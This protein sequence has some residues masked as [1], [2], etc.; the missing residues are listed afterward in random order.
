M[1]YFYRKALAIVGVLIL[2]CGPVFA[3][4]ASISQIE[5][6]V[7]IKTAGQEK[8]K[9]AQIDQEVSSGD[10]VRTSSES[11]AVIKFETGHEAKIS[12]QSSMEIRE[13]NKEQTDL[14]LF[15]GKLRSKVRE[16][17]K[18]ES[19]S[20]RSPQAVA[21]VRGTDFEVIVADNATRLEVFEGRVEA[22]ELITGE[23]V[24]VRAGQYT[25]IK[26]N[27]SP[28]SP[29]QLESDEPG[30]DKTKAPDPEEKE[31][32]N[33]REEVRR[34]M[35]KEITREAV[36]SRAAEEIKKA[37]YEN[38]KV[39]TDVHGNR[40][41]L[42]EYIVRPKENEFKYVVLNHRENRFDFGKINFVF[43]SSLPE[44]L[45]RATEN[46]FY[47]ETPEKPEWVLTDLTSVISNTKDRVNEVGTGGDMLQDSEDNWH[48]YFE[49]FSFSVKGA[50][51]QEKTLWTREIYGGYSDAN[52]EDLTV[53]YSYYLDSGE[54]DSISERPSGEDTFHFY[55]KDTYADGTWIS[56][57]DYF[58]NDEGDIQ[59][60]RDITDSFSSK[61][62][63]S[64]AEYL[65]GLN[66]ERKYESSEFGDRD[67]DL[68]FSTKLVL[69]SG[70]FSY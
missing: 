23:S 54:P 38:G 27:E 62:D 39:M 68:V 24:E 25:N 45:N 15:K 49:N 2:I 60:T 56:T 64:F 32:G 33:I 57:D 30:T 18:D 47:A 10:L 21:G 59:T 43:D 52:Y 8:W 11:V 31:Y 16:L 29:S 58:I 70:M 66:F 61:M 40:V 55:N 44:N 6:T 42:E 4:V 35:F 7:Q 48:H 5:G 19:Y 9:E 69:D 67:I 26:K 50:E 20:I 1:Y 22:R 51:K 46:M 13:A 17:S 36:L 3:G 63:G 41:R 28:A 37:E 14:E 65:A 53:E 34:E 12:S